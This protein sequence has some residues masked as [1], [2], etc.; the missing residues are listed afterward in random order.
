[1]WQIDL[2]LLDATRTYN[3]CERVGD[4][5]DLA[6]DAGS[7]VLDVAAFDG[8]DRFDAA[9]VCLGGSQGPKA[10]TI[11]EQA[12]H[13]GVIALDQV[14]SPLTIDTP[15]AVEV[16]IV[17]LIDLTDDAPLA[18]CLVGHGCHRPVQPHTF[19]RFVE[20]CLRGLCIPPCGQAEIYHLSVYID[21]SP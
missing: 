15:N 2:R 4:E 3:H 13:R 6:F 20:K 12:L 19:D 9:Q 21:G 1:M 17:S 14:V 11:P 10:L 18:M 8:S 5:R 7:L 16:W